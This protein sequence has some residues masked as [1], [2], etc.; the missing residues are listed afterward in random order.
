MAFFVGVLLG[1][2]PSLNVYHLRP[3]NGWP[4]CRIVAIVPVERRRAQQLNVLADAL[5][6]VLTALQNDAAADRVE[7]ACLKL[8]A[9]H[10]IADLRRVAGL[11]GG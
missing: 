8:S 9:P 6:L 7:L 2:G 4:G 1:L 11:L 10:C 3:V 5:S